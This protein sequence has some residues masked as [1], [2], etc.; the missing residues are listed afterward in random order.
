VFSLWSHDPPD[1]AY[2]AELERVFDDVRA[3]VIRFDS[4][5]ERPDARH[6]ASN[7]VYIARRRSS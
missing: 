3:E 4:A 6:D 2:E 7:T 5:L 1:A